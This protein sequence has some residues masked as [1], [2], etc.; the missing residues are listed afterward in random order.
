MNIK[1][2]LK[3]SLLMFFTAQSFG[4]PCVPPQLST[5]AFYDPDIVHAWIK[6][7][8]KN[9]IPRQIVYL[10]GGCVF[11]VEEFTPKAPI[12]N[13]HPDKNMTLE[14]MLCANGQFINMEKVKLSSAKDTSIVCEYKESL[15]CKN[16]PKKSSIWDSF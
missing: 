14:F 8:F 10:N 3:F 1:L 6:I 2:V 4:K 13:I 9:D 12:K 7:N 15:V 16:Q 11:G 5:C